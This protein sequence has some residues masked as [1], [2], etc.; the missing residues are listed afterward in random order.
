MTLALHLGMTA[1][2][3]ERSITERELGDWQQLAAE[4]MLPL[5]RIEMYLAQIAHTAARAS[6]MKKR[7][8]GELTLAEFLFE[9]VAVVEEAANDITP[10]DIV[11]QFGSRVYRKRR[12]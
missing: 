1:D 4:D 2:G 9:P 7:G 12:G 11:K 5:K 6:G 8:G 3:L 10:A